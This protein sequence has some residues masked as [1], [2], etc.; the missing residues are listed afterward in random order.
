MVA[1]CSGGGGAKLAAV[2]AGGL[3]TETKT[4]NLA[5]LE[6]KG[7]RSFLQSTVPYLSSLC[8]NLWCEFGGEFG[9]LLAIITG[10][11]RLHHRVSTRLG[12]RFVCKPSES[13]IDLPTYL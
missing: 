10:S 12:V 13:K 3:H 4:P 5:N 11:F 7:T 8:T 2:A 1:I 9:G 6:A